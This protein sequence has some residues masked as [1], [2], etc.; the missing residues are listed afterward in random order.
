MTTAAVV[1]VNEVYRSIQG[2]S[3]YA[4]MPCVFIRL[5][6]C[7]LRC[8]Y[9]DTAYAFHEGEA[10]TVDDLLVRA[11]AMV[12]TSRDHFEV[13]GGEPLAQPGATELIARL[14]DTGRPVLVETS[15][16]VDIDRADRRAVRIMD[17]KTPGSGESRRNDWANLDRLTPQ[18]QV[19][20]VLTDRD[21]YA[22]MRAV[23]REHALE[24]KV[25]AVLASPVQAVAAGP[26][27][28]GCEG[29]DL[30]DLA[31]WV[32]ADAL[33]VRVQVQLH[34]LVWSPTARGV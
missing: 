7:P 4:G 12:E 19:K 31:E 33:P 21:D 3:T 23:V 15:G 14:C 27:V 22:W 32:L 11:Q 13:T 5:R 28:A 6:G 1:R 30:R 29:L 10:E 20:F 8:R 17:L 9:C 2:E 24:Q 16:A 18:D 34:K 26:D 25:A